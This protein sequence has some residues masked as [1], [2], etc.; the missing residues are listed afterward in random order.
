MITKELMD[1]AIA[2][3]PMKEVRNR[4]HTSKLARGHYKP[5]YRLEASGV[6]EVQ[7]AIDVHCHAD[8]L[9][10]DPLA[11]AKRAS[12]N[13]MGGIVY[14]TIGGKGSSTQSVQEVREALHRWCDEKGI[15]PSRV[16]SAYGVGR[17]WSGISRK[18]VEENLDEGC[19]AIWM[20]VVTH[21]YSVYMQSHVQPMTWE[22]A[23]SKG[24]YLLD[25]HGQLLPEV[26]DILHLVA[27]RNVPLSMG[28]C[29]QAERVAIAE[30]V[31][32]IGFKKC[33]IDHPFSD[34]IGATMDQMKQF[35]ASG[36]YLNFIWDELSPTLGIDP[37]EM[38]QAVKEIGA[39]HV[40]F[41]SDAQGGVLYPEHLEC[42]RL[43]RAYAEAFGLTRDE[44]YQASTVNPAK[45]LDC[46]GE[47]PAAPLPRTPIERGAGSRG[48]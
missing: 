27:D 22:E 31:E 9:Q 21:A 16:W 4:F 7:H 38:F 41:S 46:E 42:I 17:G 48:E 39:D 6:P 18:L 13:G 11:M 35:A 28:H 29:Q 33:F 37:M 1:Q 20:P 45:L 19:A 40:L 30:E 15:T 43:M 2:Q 14:K 10:Q 34:Y 23:L 47:V 44:I 3:S 36:I 24:Y 25:Q 32:K 26:R 12:K 8:S 5:D